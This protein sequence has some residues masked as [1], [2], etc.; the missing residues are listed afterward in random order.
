MSK[1]SGG[2]FEGRLVSGEAPIDGEVL[3]WDAAAGVWRPVM[4]SSN[5]L[6]PT[7]DFDVYID[8][9]SG[10]NTNTG[11]TKADP[12]ATIGGYYDRY[13]YEMASGAQVRV[14]LA[15]IGGAD[16]WVSPVT[17]QTYD[18]D[19]IRFPMQRLIDNQLVFRG[20]QNMVAAT[21]A[22][23]APATAALD[24]G[25]P[26]RVVDETNT[27]G[28]GWRT[29]ILFT[30]AAPGWAVNDFGPQSI[31][32]F[33]RVTRAGVKRYWEIPIADNTA[34]SIL[35]DTLNIVADL[36]GA[37]DTAEIV[38]PGALIRGT[39]LYLG[40][41][42]FLQ[43]VG[44]GAIPLTNLTANMGCNFERLTLQNV[45]QA[46]ARGIS[47]DRV[48]FDGSVGTNEGLNASGGSL[49]V[50]NCAGRGRGHTL[51]QGAALLT[52]PDNASRP[53]GALDPA[54]VTV[55][56]TMMAREIELSQN[57]SA[58]FSLPVSFYGGTAFGISVREGAYFTQGTADYLGGDSHT[59]GG[60][61]ASEGG[62]AQIRA[63]AAPSRTTITG[64][65]VDL[66][67]DGIGAVAYGAG[68][69]QF[70]GAPYGGNLHNTTVAA[71]VPSGQMS[72]IYI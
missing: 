28:A 66:S 61:G 53:D 63:G 9:V 20:P 11:L 15:G 56:V 59:T 8:G 1:D 52:M 54:L 7:T 45:Q 19:M 2:S 26:S 3:T 47:Y 23:G 48:C 17:A 4:P 30:G 18:I 12:L 41:Q 21:P 67:A 10:S 64:G 51:T 29:E 58:R 22:G 62:S 38:V 65:G 33:L 6:P 70:E 25:L 5:T 32:A 44:S 37:T 36:N 60:I 40:V 24:V 50:V 42:R 55:I 72:R 68:G 16:P 31:G 13:G 14:H 27:P 49:F 34:D 57:A 71:G 69:G 46:G 39:T 35:V 43:V